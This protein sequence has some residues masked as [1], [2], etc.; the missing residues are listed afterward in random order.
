MGQRCKVSLFHC[1]YDRI[2]CIGSFCFCETTSGMVK[3]TLEVVFS[4]LKGVLFSSVCK[5]G[6]LSKVVRIEVF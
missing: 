1:S 3:E 5:K 4:H 6:G 2:A